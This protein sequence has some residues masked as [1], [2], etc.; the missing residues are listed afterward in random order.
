M[1]AF[2][3]HKGEKRH[4]LYPQAVRAHDG[5]R[6]GNAISRVQRPNVFIAHRRRGQARVHGQGKAGRRAE[7]QRGHG[8]ILP[9]N[10]CILGNRLHLSFGTNF[11][12]CNE[13]HPNF[14]LDAW[15]CELT[16]FF[17]HSILIYGWMA[18]RQLS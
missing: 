5:E 11:W 16:F 7:R 4:L 10:I 17:P 14:R 13:K 18:T 2:A 6:R 1:L 12:C 8:S 15:R 9:Y 3:F